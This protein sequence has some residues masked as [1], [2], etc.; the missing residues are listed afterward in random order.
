MEDK[1]VSALRIAE[2]I[3]KFRNG[4]LS[5]TEEIELTKWI[6]GQPANSELFEQLSDEKYITQSID[7]V[8]RIDAE[9]A[10]ERVKQRI[11]NPKKKTTVIR[12][13]Y[14]KIGSIAA[15]VILIAIMFINREGIADLLHPIHYR[16]VT[17]MIGERKLVSLADGTKVWL[18]PAS[19]LNYPD[20]FKGKTRDIQLTGEAFLE[21]AKDHEHPFKVHTGQIT[22]TVLGT[23]FDL[24][25][26][27]DEK[28]ISVILLTG[29]VSFSDGKQQTIIVPNQRAIFRK[30][31][32]TILKQAYPDAR[33]MLARRDGNLQYNNVPVSEIIADLRRNYNMN[34]VVEGNTGNCDFF[35]RLNNGEDAG[36]F[37]RKLCMVIGAN[38]TIK[39]NTYIISG[40]SCL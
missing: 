3:S 30:T 9:K 25:A 38:L 39:D 36:T 20:R 31:D 12:S 16:G 27:A 4:A 5:E 34:I 24:K 29:K 22:T 40:G 37:I 10:F 15:S 2:L 23:S 14:I 17:T 26:Y 7:Q 28:E 11:G 18:G 8:R 13:L 32:H 6:V 19:R 35:G 1:E 21:V 33:N